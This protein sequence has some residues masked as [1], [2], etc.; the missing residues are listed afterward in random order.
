[1]AKG[2]QRNKASPREHPPYQS[3]MKATKHKCFVGNLSLL[4]SR[5]TGF[6]AGIDMVEDLPGEEDR[7]P[8]DSDPP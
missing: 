5:G 8:G 1:M 2:V 3:S 6:Q 4:N 7:R